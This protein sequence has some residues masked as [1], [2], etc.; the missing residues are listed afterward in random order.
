MQTSLGK[1]RLPELPPDN[2]GAKTMEKAWVS[3]DG[4]ACILTGALPAPDTLHRFSDLF[5]EEPRLGIARD[6]TR[7][8]TG[9]GMLYQTRHLRPK[10]DLAIDAEIP[11]PKGVSVAKRLVRLGGEGRIAHIE[12]RQG[13]ISLPPLPNS[14]PWRAASSSSCLPLPALGLGRKVGYRSALKPATKTAYACGRAGLPK[15]PS[16]CVPL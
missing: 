4:L 11:M 13:G 8:V 14:I 7:R 1:V 10:A 16:R 6:N 15:S 3:G 5:M 12:T 2:A 9:E